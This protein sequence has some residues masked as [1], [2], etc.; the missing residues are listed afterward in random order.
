MTLGLRR[1]PLGPGVVGEG[2]REITPTL[3]PN[4][5]G[6]NIALKTIPESHPTPR[7]LQK[8]MVLQ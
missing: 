4:P 6:F 8:A 7:P 1:G 5:K 3:P 2:S